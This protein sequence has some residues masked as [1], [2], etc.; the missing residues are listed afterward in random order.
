MSDA[1]PVRLECFFDCSSPWTYMG[2]HNIQ[3]VAERLGVPIEWKPIIVGGVFNKVNQ[4]VYANRENPPVPL[5]AA[6]TIKDMQDWARWSGLVINHPPACGHPVNAVKCMR[7]CLVVQPLGKLVPFAR[8]AFE[9][10]WIHG[11]D[12]AKDE[13]LTAVCDRAGVDAEMVLRE[14]A[15]PELKARLWDNTN[16][17][18][19][20]GGFGSPTFF[21]DGDDMYF[22]NDRV[23]LVEDA[24]RRRQAQL[25]A[26]A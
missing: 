10:L 2:F 6:Y 21:V 14:I 5:K 1:R 22:G 19:D 15:T 3:P 8:A 18:M 17:L 7:A 11:Q 20:R 12:L 9:A 26:T 23:M 24:V 4:V 16:E 13:V 25:A